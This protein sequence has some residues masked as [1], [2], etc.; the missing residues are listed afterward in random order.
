[1][2]IR[3]SLSLRDQIDF[4]YRLQNILQAGVPLLEALHLLEQCS[5]KHWKSFL[6]HT[7]QG[8]KRGNSLAIS[9]ST[10]TNGLVQFVLG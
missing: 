8:L 3:R 7:I 6:S 2:M 10:R 4:T 5:P 1:M 9:L